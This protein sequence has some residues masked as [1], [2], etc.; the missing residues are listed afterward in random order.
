MKTFLLTH[1]LYKDGSIIYTSDN[2][3]FNIPEE[4]KKMLRQFCCNSYANAFFRF[5]KPDPFK[6]YF[7]MWNLNPDECIPFIKCAFGHLIFYHQLKYKLLN[8]VYNCIDILGKAGDLEF[9]M[10]ILLCDRKGLENSFF[11]DIYEQSFER[12]GPPEI[13]EI[14]A[15][16]PA[17][18]LGGSRNASNVRKLSMD[19]EM[20]I[21]SQL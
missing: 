3:K 5:V 6:F 7:S 14:Y 1:K 11:I 21:L 19:K 15:F 12:L 17:I 13:D 4:L 16:I 10:D 18:G 8:P 2:T 9:V 20:M